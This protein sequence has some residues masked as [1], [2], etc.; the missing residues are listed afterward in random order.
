MRKGMFFLTVMAMGSS[1]IG[2]GGGEQISSTLYH[3]Q[4][5]P[6][7]RNEPS[8]TGI[9]SDESISGGIKQTPVVDIAFSTPTPDKQPPLS[10][11][12]KQRGLRDLEDES[13]N[14]IDLAHIQSIEVISKRYIDPR[15]K[16]DYVHSTISFHNGSAKS[17]LL[18][19]FDTVI[20]AVEIAQPLSQDSRELPKRTVEKAWWLRDLHKIDFIGIS[21]RLPQ[22]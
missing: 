3:P 19:P 6:L 10:A 4:S 21:G 18:F 15:D 2:M 5:A 16:K 9:V 13:H 14:A 8:Y 22:K 20:S 12:T 11:I 1:I 17:Q 7:A